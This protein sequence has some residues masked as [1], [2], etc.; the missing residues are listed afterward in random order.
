[1]AH[2]VSPVSPSKMRGSYQSSGNMG[3]EVSTMTGSGPQAG[4][5]SGTT[6][7]ASGALTGEQLLSRIVTKFRN[8]DFELLGTRE[9]AFLDLGAAPGGFTEFLLNYTRNETR[10]KIVRGHAVTL[11]VESGGHRLQHA[12]SKS[13]STGATLTVQYADV[14]DL[15]PGAVSCGVV[16][17]VV[18]DVKS[19]TTVSPATSKRLCVPSL[20]PWLVLLKQ[21]AL[22]MSKLKSHGLF[23][24]RLDFEIFA[25][26]NVVANVFE[27]EVHF[28]LLFWCLQ[29]LLSLFRGIEPTQ[30]GAGFC[31]VS[32]HNFKAASFQSEDWTQRFERVIDAL[33]GAKSEED[34]LTHLEMAKISRFSTYALTPTA[35]ERRSHAE[36]FLN[37]VR[38]KG[39]PEMN[40]IPFFENLPSPTSTSNA[41]ADASRTLA[42]GAEPRYSAESNA[43]QASVL[44]SIRSSGA[45][46]CRPSSQE[47]LNNVQR[48]SAERPSTRPGT[49]VFSASAST[50]TATGFHS[51]RGP[52]PGRS[53]FGTNVPASGATTRRPSVEFGTITGGRARGPSLEQRRP[54][55]ERARA[56]SVERRPSLER[57][58]SGERKPLT[59]TL[60]P[61]SNRI[62]SAERTKSSYTDSAGASSRLGQ[63]KATLNR[64]F[65]NDRSR[66]D[67]ENQANTTETISAQ[68]DN[69]KANETDS[70]S[71][72]TS[73]LSAGL[74]ALR[75]RS[76]ERLRLLEKQRDELESSGLSFSRA[77]ESFR[78]AASE[79]ERSG[80]RLPSPS[81][82][83]QAPPGWD[84]AAPRRVAR[85]SEASEVEA[86]LGPGHMRERSNEVSQRDGGHFQS[87]TQPVLDQGILRNKSRA[88][89]PN[90]RNGSDAPTT[91]VNDS[92]IQSLQRGVIRKG[93]VERA[94]RIF[95]QSKTIS[96]SSTKTAPPGDEFGRTTQPLP[97]HGFHPGAG[98]PGA[99][100][101]SSGDVATPA[102]T[103]GKPFS[104]T[105]EGAPPL[106]LRTSEAST[107]R[108]PFAS[109]AA[110]TAAPDSASPG[111]LSAV[112]Q[113][114]A[115]GASPLAPASSSSPGGHT[116]TLNCEIKTPASCNRL[117][118][119]WVAGAGGTPRSGLM[120]MTPVSPGTVATESFSA[121]ATGINQG[122]QARQAAAPAVPEGNIETNYCSTSSP[123]SS[124]P[125]LLISSSAA[126]N[127]TKR[128]SI[129]SF[130]CLA[131]MVI[132]GSSLSF[133]LLAIALRVVLV[134]QPRTASAAI[135]GSGAGPLP[136][137]STSSTSAE[138]PTA[139]ENT[140]IGTTSTSRI[141]SSASSASSVV[142]S[143]LVPAEYAALVFDSGKDKFRPAEEI[144]LFEV[145]C[146]NALSSAVLGPEFDSERGCVE[147]LSS[148]K[149]TWRG[150]ERDLADSYATARDAAAQVADT[151]WELVQ[152][153]GGETKIIVELKTRQAKTWWKENAQPHVDAFVAAAK[154]KS[155]AL[156][157]SVLTAT[158]PTQK[159]T[160]GKA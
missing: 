116:S 87:A 22:G 40:Q 120:E 79:R 31:Y 145:P 97:K 104:Y 123:T 72:L 76:A 47:R 86:G 89:P 43:S 137:A 4:G 112:S 15:L 65:S 111:P 32:V 62:P 156:A 96:S 6:R 100:S 26:G 5:P 68:N 42:V 126:A 64:R 67:K 19:P 27:H 82:R 75:E 69:T 35:N 61:A 84:A 115:N 92:G 108:T 113:A 28:R 20:R 36:R 54:S 157:A 114:G 85:D 2:F 124:R 83:Q 57:K 53:T 88:S 119:G 153:Y 140:P 131:K 48:S 77:H 141:A 46:L 160:Q 12:P 101:A 17:I 95:E 70:S 37:A 10:Q 122:E 39:V 149:Q 14:C 150:F 25:A 13:S 34:L 8:S 158:T 135:A 49:S 90:A 3:K 50:R 98:S 66:V 45:S 130:S 99:S 91:S 139:S 142:L 1:M 151:V 9:L 7:N 110:R 30:K 33:C 125:T 144:L 51:G 18:S 138:S 134:V 23:V 146:S 94:R 128:R 16:D 73:R 93:S 59:S 136:T 132:T 154:S 58:F 38:P 103:S 143:V 129:C 133:V 105:G 121:T 117:N 102:S 63:A 21:F 80:T 56:P 44:S 118:N 24:F 41:N 159:T 71:R 81:T 152:E 148:V 55:L 78:S 155:E 147:M 60:M 107:F 11:P 127:S 52:S 74:S 29:A 109:A 106:G